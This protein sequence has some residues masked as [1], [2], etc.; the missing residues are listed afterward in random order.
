MI[1]RS[2]GRIINMTGGG[3]ATSFPSGSGYA[4]SKAGL[5]RFTECVSDT[6]AGSGVLVF[7]MD[8]GL[9]Q[10]RDDRIPAHERGRPNASA[11]HPAPV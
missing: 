5:L 1:A 4:T 6:L 8:P 2:R 7:A 10:H 3:T 9:V 11:Q